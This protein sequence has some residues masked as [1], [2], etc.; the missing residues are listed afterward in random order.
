MNVPVAVAAVQ[1]EGEAQI[2]FMA[3]NAQ[4]PPDSLGMA[5]AEML[6]KK[7]EIKLSKN[8]AVEING[9]E[10]Y[11]ITFADNS[12][13]KPV[14][15]QVYWIKTDQLLFNVIGVS[16]PSQTETING[17]VNSIKKLSDDEKATIKGLK[18]RLAEAKDGELLNDLSL[19]TN[20]SWN[21]ET[22]S[23]MNDIDPNV[24]LEAGQVLKIAVREPYLVQ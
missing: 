19:R 12:G 23:L 22:T 1:P 24:Q 14:E 18:I 3:D 16:Y 11:E 15:Y 8:K 20:N 21:V 7:Y 5:F 6:Q 9:F 13:S 10:G 4:A 17:I 2:I